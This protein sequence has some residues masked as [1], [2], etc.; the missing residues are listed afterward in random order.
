MVRFFLI[1]HNPLQRYCSLCLFGRVL[2]C[3]GI[4]R[5]LTS[6]PT[7]GSDV[8]DD[9]FEE[10]G[11]GNALSSEVKGELGIIEGTIPYLCAGGVACL[12]L[13]R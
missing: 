2:V 1:K 5:A 4:D 9:D 8:E 10:K 7:F 6:A 11:E 13:E 3:A 12:L